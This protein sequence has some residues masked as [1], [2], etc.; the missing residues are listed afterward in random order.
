MK[1]ESAAD[2]LPMEQDPRGAVSALRDF[3][4]VHASFIYEHDIVFKPFA[5][6]VE[7]G[8]HRDVHLLFS[9]LWL[10]DSIERP[11]QDRN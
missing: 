9:T 8:S 5:N 7:P 6:T 3:M 11:P 2:S 1:N 10:V 4:A